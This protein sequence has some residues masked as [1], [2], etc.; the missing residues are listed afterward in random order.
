[1]SEEAI[2]AAFVNEPPPDVHVVNTLAAAR[3]AAQRLLSM[4]PGSV[5]ACDTEV[6]DIDVRWVGGW[7]SWCGCG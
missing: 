7:L 3:A 5:F 4:P 1:V 6:M 2:A